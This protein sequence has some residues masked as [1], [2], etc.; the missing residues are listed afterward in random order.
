MHSTVIISLPIKIHV[1]DLRPECGGPSMRGNMLK[2]YCCIT[3]VYMCGWQCVRYNRRDKKNA[4]IID[5]TVTVCQE[6]QNQS[7]KDV[8]DLHK[9]NIVTVTINTCLDVVDV[10]CVSEL[11][12][13][14]SVLFVERVC[15]VDFRIVRQFAVRFHCFLKGLTAK[16]IIN[17][18]DTYSYALHR[19]YI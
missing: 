2:H 11:E 1:A 15:L 19:Q 6:I 10:D 3:E 18:R 14:V 8:S 9:M 4:K 5:T 12:R 13:T 17:D 7:D 16:R